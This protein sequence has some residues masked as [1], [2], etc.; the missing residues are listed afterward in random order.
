MRSSRIFDEWSAF[1]TRYPGSATTGPARQLSQHLAGF[2]V[3]GKVFSA[4][5]R[6]AK[7][8]I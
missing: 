7:I 3:F 2:A 6:C 5:Q 4:Q 8:K 1:S